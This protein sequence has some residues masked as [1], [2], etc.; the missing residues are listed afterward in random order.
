VS[1]PIP[2][3]PGI[4]QGAAHAGR[5]LGRFLPPVQAGSA[6]AWLEQRRSLE[7]G[8]LNSGWLLEPFGASPELPVEMARAGY[9]VL[10]A[11]NNPIARFLIELQAC[12]PTE[13]ELRSAL[14]ELA[15]AQRAGERIE[16][17]IRALYQ[18]ECAQCGHAVE[19]QAFIWDRESNSPVA[20]IYTCAYCKD[21]GERP[22]SPGDIQR[23]ASYAASGMHRAR[24]L[25][26]VARLDDPDRAYAE[27]ALNVYLPRAVYGLFT[28]VNRLDSLPSAK[29]RLVSALLLAAF[30]Q[31]NVLW[32]HPAKSNRPRQ[33]SIP[34]RFHEKNLWL[35]LENA[36]EAWSSNHGECNVPVA[37]WPELPPE[38]GGICLFEGR[39]KDLAAQVVEM[40]DRKV[41]I[42]A[43]L[44]A[45]PRPNQAFWTLSALWAGWLWGQ[46][47]SSSFKSV[48]RRRRYDWSWQCVALSSAFN[49]LKPLLEPGTPCVGLMGEPEAGF[50][51][52]AMVA[53]EIAGLELEGL[54]LRSAPEQAQ[55]TWK[56]GVGGAESREEPA[57]TARE[58][59][60]A[61]RQ[62]LVQERVTEYLRARGEPAHYLPVHAAALSGLAEAQLLSYPVEPAQEVGLAKPA[63]LAK[64]AER[65]KP[66]QQPQPGEPAGIPGASPAESLHQVE[67][68]IEAALTQAGHFARYAG[69][70]RSLETG[71]W[72]LDEAG[73]PVAEIAEPL[74]DQLEVALV[75]SLQEHGIVQLHEIDRQLCREFPG[76]FTPDLELVQQCLDSY[77]ELLPPGMEDPAGSGQWRLRQAETPQRRRTDLA[78]MQLL[79]MQI[80]KRLGYTLVKPSNPKAAGARPPLVWQN[81]SGVTQYTFHLIASGV[82]GRI[83][84]PGNRR[85]EYASGKRGVIVLPGSRAGWVEY[86]LLSDPRLRNAVENGWLLVK[87]RHVRWLAQNDN[88]SQDNLEELLALDPL[89]NKDRQMTLL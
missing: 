46:A 20:K 67:T 13:S 71:Q 42:S 72:W 36:V 43:A 29:R 53:A 4:T 12:P 26:R 15:S 64:P 68:T 83:I 60:S 88:L 55:I 51:S 39:L 19:A 81:Q 38:S 33:L 6:S 7:P 48:L 57:K 16:P 25:E 50:L 18:T 54:A 87:F 40:P 59:S 61:E 47:A 76:L 73:L 45:L 85:R 31:A 2:F 9:R 32:A 78:E 28:L 1:R 70:S 69:S 23:A 44:T 58:T 17:H 77:A 21:S 82:L 84:L 37:T 79:L 8:V 62:S 89:T 11:V 86:R 74:A 24:A 66:A 65:P 30:D 56:S 27:E 5:P 22:A 80:G 49:S 3:L 14:A 41:E 34:P 52:A 10:A 75:N 35:A 63:Q